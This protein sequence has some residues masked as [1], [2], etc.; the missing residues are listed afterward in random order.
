MKQG[1]SELGKDCAGMKISCLI[2]TRS[3]REKKIL[4]TL[5]K[6]SLISFS[7][8]GKS[9]ELKEKTF[10]ARLKLVSEFNASTV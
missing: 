9:C 2:K 6:I 10:S 7:T 5:L 1:Q 8:P 3:H 4:V